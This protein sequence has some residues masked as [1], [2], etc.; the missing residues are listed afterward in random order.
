MIG[1]TL[2]YN[3]HV[4]IITGKEVVI[5]FMITLPTDFLRKKITLLFKMWDTN[6][7]FV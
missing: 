3:V 6:W 7:G 4:R 2:Y 1:V 5:C